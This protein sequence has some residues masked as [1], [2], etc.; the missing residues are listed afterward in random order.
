M[1]KLSRKEV[2][3]M[4][5]GLVQR[6]VARYHSYHIFETRNGISGNLNAILIFRATRQNT[7]PVVVWL[8]EHEG[9]ITLAA[10]YLV[11]PGTQE[12]RS[13]KATPEILP[14]LEEKFSVALGC[15]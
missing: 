15:P 5:R 9:S 13:V 6:L 4:I 10:T 7:T 8:D 1:A 2:E 12:V 11:G 14:M 3:A